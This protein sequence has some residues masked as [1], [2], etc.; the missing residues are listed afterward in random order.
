MNKFNIAII[1]FSLFNLFLII[2][3]E[4]QTYNLSNLIVDISALSSEMTTISI[5]A[6]IFNK[7][8]KEYL[9]TS[10]NKYFY[11]LIV[12]LHL[13]LYFDYNQLIG[14]ILTKQFNIFSF[15]SGNTIMGGLFLLLTLIRLSIT[16]YENYIKER[17][18]LIGVSNNTSI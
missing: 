1:L 15:L 8:I 13:T 9:I 11:R 3:Y 14:H 18:Q 7:E 6:Y 17:K 2:G 10:E 12:T 16:K 5:F 4:Y